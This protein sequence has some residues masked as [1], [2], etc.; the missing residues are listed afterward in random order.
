MKLYKYIL[1]VIVASAPLSSCNY[2]DKEPDTEVTLEMV[3]NDKARME[4]MLAY[5]YDGLPD[6][7]WGYTFKYGMSSLGDDLRP[8]WRWHQW[9]WDCNKRATGEW[10]TNTGWNG[11]VWANMPHRIREAKLFQENVHAIP[12]DNV[13]QADVELMKLECRALIAYYYWWFA[14]WYGPCPFVEGGYVYD[15]S[16]PTNQLHFG[17]RP[18][19]EIIDWCDKELKTIADELPAA[20]SDPTKFGRVDKLF[21]L[22]TRARML[23]FNA[24]PLVNGNEWYKDHADREGNKLFP[25]SYDATKWDRALAACKELVDVAEADGH[26]LYTAYN[27][28]GT[29][30]PFMS[31]LGAYS[32]TALSGNT[33]VLFAKYSVDYGSYIRY[34]GVRGDTGANGGMS[35]SQSLV[36]A[37]AMRNGIYPIDDYTNDSKGY[38][39]TPVINPASGYD[40]SG[41]ASDDVYY[42]TKWTG[43]ESRNGE[44]AKVT[45]KDTYNMYVNREPRFYITVTYNEKWVDN[46]Q[47]RKAN[48]YNSKMAGYNNSLVGHDKV[49]ND[50]TH[51]APNN[52]YLNNK[53]NRPEDHLKNGTFAYRQGKFYGLAEAY[54][55]Y[56]ECLNEVKPGDPDILVYLNKIRV[57]AGVP[58]YIWGAEEEGKIS[59][60][61]D[62]AVMRDLIRRERR[63]ELCCEDTYIRYTDIRRWMIAEQV[64][65]GVD[66][67]H[68]GMNYKGVKRSCDPKDNDEKTGQAFFVRTANEA[69]RVWK[70]EYYWMPIFQTEIDKNPNLVQAPYWET[71]T[72]EE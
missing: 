9:S 35:V 27:D 1:T 38:K 16:T 14:Y 31:L 17:P 55:N 32:L 7:L 53:G 65:E 4:G 50:D 64:C 52:G 8:S 58:E 37:F 39:F 60:S 69:K 36:D 13:T 28:D 42:K 2:L 15:P 54:L 6:P 43:A 44:N 18:W 25:Q 56:V 57:R 41:F 40:E 20:Y 71:I 23:L 66:Y 11:D 12:A 24:S 29:V 59:V 70:R 45:S 10:A 51:D 33:E 19:D 47:K 63:V 72:E 26:A 5:V 3:F 22:A 46:G 62:Q 61:K 30:D 49:D 34:G 67:Y 48:F 21:C 68:G